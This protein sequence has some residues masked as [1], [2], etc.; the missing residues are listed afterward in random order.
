[1]I[2]SSCLAGVT[3]AELR[4]HLANKKHDWKYL[5]YTFAKTKFP[6]TEKLTNGALVTP[7]PNVWRCIPNIYA[8]ETSGG[9]SQNRCPLF[10][11][12]QLYII[13][14]MQFQP[15]L[16]NGRDY[17][18]TLRFTLI[19]VSKKSHWWIPV[20]ALYILHIDLTRLGRGP[21]VC[22]YFKVWHMSLLSYFCVAGCCYLFLCCRLIPHK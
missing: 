8:H 4:R 11:L 5:T 17:L 20:I 15:T 13:Y 16:Y 3:A 14:P 10:I 9:I 22:V 7:T 19:Q 18:N 2:S 12:R 21:C 1:M 6:V